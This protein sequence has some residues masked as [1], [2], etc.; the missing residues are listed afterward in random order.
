MQSDCTALTH[1]IE[2]LTHNPLLLMLFLLLALAAIVLSATT[3]WC[4]RKLHK[5]NYQ[6]ALLCDSLSIGVMVVETNSLR[7]QSANSAI[8]TMLGISPNPQAFHQGFFCHGPECGEQMEKAL[9]QTRHHGSAQIVWSYPSDCDD[10]V[11]YLDVRL[12]A[13]DFNNTACTL[14][15]CTDI[16]SAKHYEESLHRS[17]RLYRSVITA[18][19]EGVMVQKD[20]GEIIT[21]NSA[22]AQLLGICPQELTGTTLS[23]LNLHAIYPDGA[24]CVPSERPTQKAL[25]TKQAQRNV[26]MGVYRPDSSLVWL[27]L[28]AEPIIP[29]EGHEPAMVVTTATNI[30]ELNAVR[31]RMEQITRHIPGFV[32]QFQQQRHGLGNFTYISQGMESLFGISISSALDHPEIAFASIYPDDTVKLLKK[33]RQAVRNN[34]ALQ[35]EFRYTR[36]DGEVIWLEAYSMPEV[37]AEG[38]TLW[39]GYVF[40]ITQRKSA[41]EALS[42]AEQN[43]HKFIQHADIIFWVSIPGKVIYI[44]PAYERLW[45]QCRQDL[46]E[47]P[48]AFLD[49]IHPADRESTEL[50]V[51]DCG[52]HRSDFNTEYRI[53]RSDGQ[54]RW[55]HA[56][57]KA[58]TDGQGNFS[59]WIGTAEDVTERMEREEML[60]QFSVQMVKKVEEELFYREQA[61]LSY[62][63]LFEN[64]PE[65]IMLLDSEGSILAANPATARMAGAKTPAELC[66]KK[67][68]SLFSQ[69]AFSDFTSKEIL[70]YQD[71]LHCL[72]SNESTRFN[73][74]ATIPRGEVKYLEAVISRLGTNPSNQSLMLLRD[75]T[76]VQELTQ[77]Q[78]RQESYLIQKSKEAELGSMID[79]IAHQ[80][81]QPLN[82]V[83]LLAE[84]IG[85]YYRNDELT[86]A[87][88]FQIIESISL[89]VGFM[90]DTIE[91]FRAFYSPSDIPCYFQINANTAATIQLLKPRLNR[92]KVEARLALDN[93]FRIHGSPGHYRQAIMNIL[94]NAIDALS[95]SRATQ[96]TLWIST[97]RD[98]VSGRIV[99]GDNA[100][101]VPTELLPNKIFQP[102]FTTRQNCGGSGIGLYLTRIIIED[103]LKG[104]LWAENHDG[105]ACFTIEFPLAENS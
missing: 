39:H 63:T 69:F 45:G 15:T 82:S 42:Q 7:T 12:K 88:L 89:Q 27:L 56:R 36:P 16:T 52:K 100:G 76:Q 81:K 11:I 67:P 99:I 103:K 92:H 80:W 105:G 30:T 49:A 22:M 79:A 104:R 26:H 91:D 54:V 19:N 23:K 40:D 75:N 93:N 43:L 28:N 87:Q 46:Y 57:S 55:I 84:S 33:S 37:S 47:N 5:T 73:V 96:R 1:T 77:R 64:S 13:I 31:H 6:Y 74:T 62:R 51:R 32:Y 38:S 29:Q 18:M 2:A 66:G 3:A 8:C 25:Q 9:E 24:A 60:E 53:V 70:S 68:W 4:M 10:T 86:D 95:S 14:V 102:F 72:H 78:R 101:G 98:D 21:S 59:Y 20:D 90:D 94:N 44:S 85:E 97:S 34:E 17:E 58:F 41:S 50:M 61:E 83:L 65:G 71:I 35:L 48:L